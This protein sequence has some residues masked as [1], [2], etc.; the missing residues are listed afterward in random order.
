MKFKI[1]PD[2]ATCKICQDEDGKIYMAM[3]KKTMGKINQDL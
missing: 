3:M 1:T 2:E